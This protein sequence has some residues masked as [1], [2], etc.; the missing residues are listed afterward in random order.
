[1]VLLNSFP[2]LQ[3]SHQLIVYLLFQRSKRLWPQQQL[4]RPQQQPPHLF[5]PRMVLL[6]NFPGLQLS[7]QLIAYLLFQRASPEG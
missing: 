5:L 6:N 1:M 4:V 3:L 7:H 2:G